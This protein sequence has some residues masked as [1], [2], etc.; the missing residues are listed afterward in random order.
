MR[1]GA[2]HGAE[3]SP[4]RSPS[5]SAPRRPVV[6]GG[7]FTGVGMVKRSTPMRCSP[8]TTHTPATIHRHTP[9]TCP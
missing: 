5:T 2:A 8:I 4:K 6:R 3:T 9:E 1:M 7:A